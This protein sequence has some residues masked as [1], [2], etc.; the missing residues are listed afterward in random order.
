MV[1]DDVRTRMDLSYQALEGL[2][3]ALSLSVTL[4]NS[5]TELALAALQGARKVLIETGNID[6]ARACAKRSRDEL[7]A[8]YLTLA[9]VPGPRDVLQGILD[10]YDLIEHELTRYLEAHPPAPTQ[11]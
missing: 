11:A 1:Y 2:V 8:L 5:N 4:S 7:Q 9:Q 6:E 3:Q 10:N